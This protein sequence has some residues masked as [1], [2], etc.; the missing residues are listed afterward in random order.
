MKLLRFF[1][2]VLLLS[3]TTCPTDI[4]AKKDKKARKKIQKLKCELATLR[5][6]L[7]CHLEQTQEE[8]ATKN[9][10]IEEQRQELTEKDQ[11]LTE[12]DKELELKDLTLTA[13]KKEHQKAVVEAGRNLIGG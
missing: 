9:M 11:K 6:A 5:K 13:L 12:K 1:S 4:Y 2:L 7:Q 8:V 3:L 10:T